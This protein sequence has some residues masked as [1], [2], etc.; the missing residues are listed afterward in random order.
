MSAASNTLRVHSSGASSRPPLNRKLR[1][2]WE[3]EADRAVDRG[4]GRAS[5]VSDVDVFAEAYER[6]ESPVDEDAERK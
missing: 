3:D 1:E 4:R 2:G 5:C 6:P